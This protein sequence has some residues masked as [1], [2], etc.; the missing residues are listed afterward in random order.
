[1]AV[2]EENKKYTG[3]VQ[4]IKGATVYVIG[5]NSVMLEFRRVFD[6]NAGKKAIFLGID[7]KNKSEKVSQKT[8]KNSDD[9][10]VTHESY[11]L[12][13]DKN[14]ISFETEEENRFIGNE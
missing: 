1:V 7:G 5:E 10:E 6:R 4:D 2:D 11:H 8:E 12:S 13:F 14:I 9:I 3:I